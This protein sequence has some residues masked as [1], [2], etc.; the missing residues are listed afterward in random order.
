LNAG[1]DDY[2]PKPCSTADFERTLGRWCR[3]Q[4]LPA[5]GIEK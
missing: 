5:T 2:I 3:P 4:A 1:M